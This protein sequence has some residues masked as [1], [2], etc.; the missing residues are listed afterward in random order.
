[1]IVDRDGYPTSKA[2]REEKAAQKELIDDLQRDGW[3]PIISQ[4]GGI[5][6]MKRTKR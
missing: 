2:T 1:M 6:S 4:D 5:C 3:E